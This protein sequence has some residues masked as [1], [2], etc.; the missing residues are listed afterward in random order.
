MS[1]LAPTLE[2][3]FTERLLAQLRASPHTVAA[4]RDT[5]R[6]LLRFAKDRN[7]KAPSVIDIQDLDAPFI[8]AFLEHLEITRGN[9]IRTRNA[10]LAAVHSLFH[11]ASLRHPEHASL[12]QRVLAI[13]PKRFERRIVSF[14]TQ[15]EVD[16][17][18]AAP[19][20]STWIGRRDHALLVVA[21][22]T[23]LRVSE[24]IGLR[25]DDVH[26]GTGAYVRCHGKG[27]KERCTPLTAVSV[28]VLNVW[29]KERNGQPN[30]P[31]FPSRRGGMLSRDAVALLVDRHVKAAQ[32]HCPSLRNKRV[33]PHVLRH[34]SAMNLLQA[35]VDTSVIAL[36]LGHERI[37]TTQIYLHADLSLKERAVARTA[38]PGTDPGRYRP[39]DELMAFLESL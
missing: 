34:T 30:E 18:L 17:L 9:S 25:G 16:A 32:D 28:K 33:S 2:S 31:V 7:G 37:Q 27:R 19:D 4:Y 5:F 39:P 36:W 23:G 15:A 3:F 24:L 26:C 14:L 10:R 1:T 8:S 11:F 13:P 12:I 38:P 20:R 6:L 22:Q 21:V 35:G 29:F